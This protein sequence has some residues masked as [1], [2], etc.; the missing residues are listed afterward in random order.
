ME[1]KYLSYAILKHIQDSEARGSLSTDEKDGLQVALEC[2]SN[3][4]G[5]GVNDEK[6]SLQVSLLDIFRAGCE[7]LCPD[8]MKA[9]SEIEHEKTARTKDSFEDSEHFNKFL[10]SVTDRGYFSSFTPGTPEYEQRY[11][12]V[13]AKYKQRFGDTAHP[14]K[15][16]GKSVDA[17]PATE[18]ENENSNKADEYKTKGN[19]LLKAGEHE[20]ALAQY[21]KAIE[22]CQTGESSHIYYSNRAAV[23]LIL[24]KNEE[25]ANDCSA[26]I[27]LKPDYV[28]GHT[29]L[30][31]AYLNMGRKKEAAECAKSALEIDP[32]NATAKSL[33]Q[34]AGEAASSSPAA[35]AGG[36]PSMP[37]GL[38]GMMSQM[39]QD[40]NMMEQMNAMREQMGGGGGGGG[41]GGAGGMPDIASMMN[42]PAM[43]NMAQSMM[44]NPAMMNMAQQMM[45]DPN[46]LSNLMGSLGGK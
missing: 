36:L 43:M 12:K 10:K 33:L 32:Q 35:G 26:S 21:T 41:G 3:S 28:K 30:A 27:A 23:Y 31:S 42:N 14:A 44:Q 19:E 25:A 1:E 38:G 16:K 8:A 13:L 15:S 6:F 9:E 4:F 46:M 40:P 20:Q 17:S 5:I 37:G 29:R 39:M 7:T 45:Q 24:G 22:I 2:L 11:E 34:S 18:A